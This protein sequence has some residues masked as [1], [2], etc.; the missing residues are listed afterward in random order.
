VRSPKHNIVDLILPR[1][2]AGDRLSRADIAMLGHGGLMEDV[3]E[4]P[5]PRSQLI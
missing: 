3:P 5:A 2:A 1:L 4:R